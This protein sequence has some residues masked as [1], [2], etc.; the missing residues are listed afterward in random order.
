MNESLPYFYDTTIEWT[1]ARQGT[2]TAPDLPALTVAAPP[3]FK[4][5]A[6]IWT[7]E[8]M[9]VAAVNTCYM[10]T[11]LAIAE[12]SK[13][14]FVSLTCNANGK[15][16]KSQEH[17][18]QITEIRIKPKLVIRHERDQ[19]R[20]GRVLEKVEQNCLISNSIKTKVQVEPEIRVAATPEPVLVS[21]A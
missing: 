19:E 13:L 16:E 20:A 7:P 11:F 21:G 9:Y 5:H 18:Y 1:V 15:L 2:L 14:E 10:T 6:G 4:G 3:E 8:H 12:L 17:G